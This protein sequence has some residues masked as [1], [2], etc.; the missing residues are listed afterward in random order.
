MKMIKKR[1]V[2]MLGIVSA[3]V[4]LLCLIAFGIFSWRAETSILGEIGIGHIFEVKEIRLAQ[5]DYNAEEN[6]R[7]IFTSSQYFF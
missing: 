2:K 4:M 6:L 7:C 3:A 1:W 5:Y